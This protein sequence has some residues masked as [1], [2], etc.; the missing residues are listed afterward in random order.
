MEVELTSTYLIFFAISVVLPMV[1]AL[2]TKSNAPS[3]V[4]AYVLLA[5]SAV[6]GFGVEAYN[7]GG[8]EGFDW[9]VAA[10]GALV[11]FVIS[12]GTHSGALKPT[13]LTGSE[14]KVAQ[15]GR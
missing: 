10:V 7:S 5:L 12:A 6:N 11:S 9:R 13:G 15:L 2:V 4:K 3:S 8:L 14:G 1:V